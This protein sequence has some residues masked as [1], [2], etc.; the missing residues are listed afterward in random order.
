MSM[1]EGEDLSA[2]YGSVA[3]FKV[4]KH[5]SELLQEQPWIMQ[6]HS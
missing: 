2:S 4:K 1:K 6:A 3:L 5:H